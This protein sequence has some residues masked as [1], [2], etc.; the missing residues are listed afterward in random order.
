[1]QIYDIQKVS[2]QLRILCFSKLTFAIR[3]ELCKVYSNLRIKVTPNLIT[4]SRLEKRKINIV[5]VRSSELKDE[6]IREF[7]ERGH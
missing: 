4:H 3:L 7:G 5:I 6:Q 1:M 2:K